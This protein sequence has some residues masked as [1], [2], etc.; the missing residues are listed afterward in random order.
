MRRTQGPASAPQSNLDPRTVEGFGREWA[1]FRQGEELS[2]GERAHIFASYFDIFPWAELPSDSIGIDVG[3]GSGRWALL[4]APRVKHLHALDASPEALATAR[5]NLAGLSN[6]S[7][8]AAG[9]DA[10][11]LPDASL[12]FAYSLG[13]LHH[14]PDTAGAV[15]DIARKLK[16]GAPFLVYLYYALENRPLWYRAVWQASNG[17]RLA[18]SRLPYGLRLAISQVIAAT[19]YWPLA[20]AARVLDAAGRLP[21]SW[22]L[23]YYRDKSFYVLRTDAFDRFCTRLEQRFTRQQIEAMLKAAG[24]ANVRFSESEPYWC[25]V[26]AKT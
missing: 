2:A 14:V 18:I 17:A 16:P 23:A 3:C 19:V 15:R 1:T 11:P 9:V 24:F 5:Q 4:V 20:R 21:K 7:F 10:I 6:V 8:H 26:A 13:V 12:D 22:P 25:A